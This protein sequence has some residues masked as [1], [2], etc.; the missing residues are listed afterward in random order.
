MIYRFKKGANYVNK[1]PKQKNLI[2]LSQAT[3]IAIITRDS[4]FKIGA[5]YQVEDGYDCM[6]EYST[7]AKAIKV[8]D[9]IADNYTNLTAYKANDPYRNGC[10]S[11]FQ[12]PQDEEV[13]PV[14][15]FN[16]DC[17]YDAG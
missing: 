9:M 2:N 8:L 7:E 14:L 17:L 13:E 16:G 10:D 4:R 3:N 15:N 5:Y 6:G 12:M 1:E 11:V